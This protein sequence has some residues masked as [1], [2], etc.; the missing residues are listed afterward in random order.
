MDS[1]ELRAERERLGL[2][3]GQAARIFGTDPRAW[4]SMES[5]TKPVRETLRRLVLAATSLSAVL[6]F[7]RNLEPEREPLADSENGATAQRCEPGQARPD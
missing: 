1:R 7:L 2:T 5:G 6:G 4:R 3:M